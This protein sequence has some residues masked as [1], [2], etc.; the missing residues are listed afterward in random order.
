MCFVVCLAQLVGNSKNLWW[1]TTDH[2]SL[3]WKELCIQQSHLPMKIILNRIHTAECWKLQMNIPMCFCY[4]IRASNF[5]LWCGELE[6][7]ITSTLVLTCNIYFKI[8]ITKH[9]LEDT[10]IFGCFLSFDIIK[11]YV[12][13]FADGNNS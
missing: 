5:L 2:C 9:S 1:T 3:Y 7:E 13:L 6:K 4:I 12:L 11:I 10:Y 8:S